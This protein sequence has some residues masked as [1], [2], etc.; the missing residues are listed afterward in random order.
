MPANA[1]PGGALELLCPY[2]IMNPYP[3][4]SFIQN[5]LTIFE[6]KLLRALQLRNVAR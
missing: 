4:S 5:T 1:N 3:Q 6:N 2:L